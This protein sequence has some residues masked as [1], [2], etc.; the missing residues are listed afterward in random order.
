MRIL[1]LSLLIMLANGL[2]AHEYYFSFATIEVDTAEER[3]EISLKLSAHDVEHYLSAKQHDV[4]LEALEGNKEAFAF[5]KKWIRSHFRISIND[6]MQNMTFVG[7]EIENDDDL[8]LYYTI[9]FSPPEQCTF[10]IQNT[11][12]FDYFPAQQNR[13]NFKWNEFEKNFSLNRENQKKTLD[14][15]KK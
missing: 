9:D 5:F 7:K 10:T 6:A 2:H 11:L 12:L 4:A 15:A 1:I 13:I 3:I 8:I 14:Y